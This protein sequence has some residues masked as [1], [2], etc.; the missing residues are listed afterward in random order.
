MPRFHSSLVRGLLNR[1]PVGL[2]RLFAVRPV[3]DDRTEP[4]IGKSLHAGRIDLR[5]D[6]EAAGEARRLCHEF[7]TFRS[8]ANF[9]SSMTTSLAATTGRACNGGREIE[10]ARG[11][12]T[13]PEQPPTTT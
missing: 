13:R 8:G 2:S 10:A 3:A 11:A 12:G 5:G 4:C 6:R 9:M 1:R 7:E